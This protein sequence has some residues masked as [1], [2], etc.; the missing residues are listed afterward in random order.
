MSRRKNNDN[1]L[2]VKNDNDQ[3]KVLKFYYFY[4]P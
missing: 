2:E 1:G 4:P 3:I